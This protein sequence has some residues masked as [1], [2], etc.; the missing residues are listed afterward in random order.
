MARS[1]LTPAPAKSPDIS[2]P[3]LHG[4][5]QALHNPT[6]AAM[7]GL[8]AVGMAV[9]GFR[10]C[11]YL[12]LTSAKRDPMRRFG[13]AERT[14]VM[15]RAGGRCEFRGLIG[16]RCRATEKLEADHIHP[17]AR[18]GSTTV[19]NGQALCSRHNREKAAR[20][21]FAWEV[22]RLERR[23]AAYFPTGEPR[24]VVR[25][26]QVPGDRVRRAA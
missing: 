5:A 20:I 24:E 23:R 22:R 25:R 21:P 16:G 9:R 19:R 14:A 8:L 15:R 10:F 11:A 1:A 3:V 17:W 13:G 26:E 4:F 12:S 2:G 7:V 18:G 6:V